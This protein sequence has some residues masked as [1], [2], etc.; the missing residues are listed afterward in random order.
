MLRCLSIERTAGSGLTGRWQMALHCGRDT[1]KRNLP[2][3]ESC[4]KDAQKS[5]AIN[6]LRP[7]HG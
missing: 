3:A 6:P 5:I 1:L 7:L 4:K 2:K